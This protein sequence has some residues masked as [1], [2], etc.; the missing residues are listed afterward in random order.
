MTLQQENLINYLNIV[1]ICSHSGKHF[2]AEGR[3]HLVEDKIKF[4]KL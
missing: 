1:N 4:T 2:M 3:K